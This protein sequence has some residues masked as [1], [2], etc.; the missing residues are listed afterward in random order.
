M[1]TIARLAT[2]LLTSL[3]VAASAQDFRIVALSDE[4]APGEA[5][6]VNFGSFDDPVLNA[7]GT[8][9]FIASNRIYSGGS[10][11]LSQVARRGDQAPGAA[12]SASFNTFDDLVL[13]ASGQTAFRAELTGA[14][15]STV[16]NAGIFSEGSG[17]LSLVAREGEQAPG[18]AA[19]V[20]FG[21]TFGSPALNASGRTAF[22]ALLAGAGV[23]GTNNTGIYSEE[24]GVLTEVARVGAQAPGA[25]AGVNFS[26]FF[27]SIVQNASGR[28]AFVA[29]LTGAGVTATNNAGIYSDGLGTLSQ[30]AREGDQAPGAAAGVNFSSLSVP[31]LNA[32]GQIAF[33]ASLTGAGVDVTNNSVIYIEESGTLSQVAREGDQAPGAA[34]GVNFSGF[35]GPLLNASGQ[36]AF[37][38][39]LTGAGVNTANDVGIYSEGSGVLSQVAR[40]GGQVPGEA[41]GVNFRSF[42]FFSLALN[43]SG[44]TAFSAELDGPGVFSGNNSGIYATDLEGQLVEI[45]R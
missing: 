12:A 26:S 42:D 43:A 9:A 27:L 44:Q 45:A 1:K 20:N 35:G 17:V 32:S 15:V 8:I 41:I 10:G 11:T 22:V 5:A 23:D 40:E 29:N 21:G 37:S 19:G 25:A 7:S 6:G 2:F 34:T 33:N 14:G 28:T 16:N 3:G 13:N 18:A 4:Q 31:R 36:T 38:A 30:V 39:S 24:S